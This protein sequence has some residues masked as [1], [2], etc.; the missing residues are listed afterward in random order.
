MRLD[1]SWRQQD[2]WLRYSEQANAQYLTFKD[3][4]DDD[5]SLILYA[6]GDDNGDD[7]DDYVHDYQHCQRLIVALG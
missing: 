4:D 1:A 6:A 7:D 2:L 3:D 5:L